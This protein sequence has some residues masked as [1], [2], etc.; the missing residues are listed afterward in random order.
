MRYCLTLDIDGKQSR[1]TITDK[2]KNSEFM[3]NT[4]TAV[5]SSGIVKT[6][7]NENDQ[8]RTTLMDTSGCCLLILLA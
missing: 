6:M 4:L 2:D 1:M 8:A 7:R 3:S 5:T